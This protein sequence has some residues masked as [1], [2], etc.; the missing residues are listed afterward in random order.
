M[1]ESEAVLRSDP[2]PAEQALALIA[3]E[4]LNLATGLARAWEPQ[5]N[6][7]A[8]GY[9]AFFLWLRGGREC[10]NIPEA[11]AGRWV[12]RRIAYEACGQPLAATPEAM[13]R[14]FNECLQIAAM[15]ASHE[16]AKHLANAL[17][18]PQ[19]GATAGET[20]R[21][22]KEVITL[23]RLLAGQSTANV[24]LRDG[25]GHARDLTRL[26]DTELAQLLALETKAETNDQK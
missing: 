15:W 7:T 24:S 13:D 19:P 26:S 16:L 18:T 20:V 6:E 22:A 8:Q 11:R 4:M 14:I 1:A 10:P 23:Y 25:T 5:P 17:G 12:Q 21:V 2:T 9:A 3:P